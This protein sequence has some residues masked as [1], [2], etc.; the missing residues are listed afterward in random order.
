MYRSLSHSTWKWC[1]MIMQ[2]P[3]VTTTCKCHCTS[4]AH[5]TV[6]KVTHHQYLFNSYAY[7]VKMIPAQCS[8]V[9]FA[10]YERSTA[11]V[12][13]FL[14]TVFVVRVMAMHFITRNRLGGDV[15]RHSKIRVL[16]PSVRHP[17][18]NYPTTLFLLTYL[19]ICDFESN[20]DRSICDVINGMPM[21]D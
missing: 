6:N 12:L 19:I 11:N 21:Y 16:N 1:T 3:T 4:N 13:L 2:S 15:I 8:S 18:M 14:E 10:A 20:F 9:I 5:L 7:T 17:K